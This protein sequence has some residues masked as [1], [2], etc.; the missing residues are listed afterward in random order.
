MG[1]AINNES[2][3]T[4]PPHSNRQLPKLKLILLASYQNHINCIQ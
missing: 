3:T 1:A 2:T 4:E